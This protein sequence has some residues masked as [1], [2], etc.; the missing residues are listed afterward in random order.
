M[1]VDE[2]FVFG[3]DCGDVEGF[4]ERGRGFCCGWYSEEVESVKS[5]S[6]HDSVSATE[7]RK[8]RESLK[9]GSSKLRAL[10]DDPLPDALQSIEGTGEAILLEGNLPQVS[11]WWQQFPKRLV[12]VPLCFSAVCCNIR[13][14]LVINTSDVSRIHLE[15]CNSWSNSV[16]FFGITYLFGLLVAW[17]K[18]IGGDT[19]LWVNTSRNGSSSHF[20]P[21]PPK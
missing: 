6:K 16:M 19:H 8:V 18:R 15:Q 9:S 11:P 5:W 1:G 4:N 20:S 3:I 7:L 2:S 17:A 10:V 12:T 21:Q 13:C 14:D